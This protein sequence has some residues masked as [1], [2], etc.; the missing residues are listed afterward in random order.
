[1][2][3]ILTAMLNDPR[4]D[5]VILIVHALDE[6]SKDQDQLLKF[7]AESS[8]IKWIASSRNWPNIEEKLDKVT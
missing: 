6:C 2:S 7:I 8:H 3:E 5:G 1:M 4:L